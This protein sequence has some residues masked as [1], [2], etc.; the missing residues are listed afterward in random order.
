MRYTSLIYLFFTL[1]LSS[2]SLGQ[3]V[4]GQSPVVKENTKKK[5]C[6]CPFDNL[7]LDSSFYDTP[8]FTAD[9][10][11]SFKGGNVALNKYIKRLIQNPAK[12][13]SDSS[14]YMVFVLFVVEKDGKIT[15]PTIVHHSDS[16]FEQEA[17]RFVSTM[18]KWQ[19]GKINGEM[20]RCWHRVILYFGYRESN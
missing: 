15:N 16:I 5:T 6:G 3:V 9:E 14:K 4:F 13:A 19:P 2:F 8:L 20:V 10:Q 1:I 7:D 17:L 12:N 11:P 18:P